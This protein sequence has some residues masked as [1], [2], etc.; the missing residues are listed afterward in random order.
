MMIV[1]VNFTVD[2]L[3]TWLNPVVRVR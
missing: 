2:L 3:Y 1:T